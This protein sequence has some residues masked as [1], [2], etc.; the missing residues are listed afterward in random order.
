[1]S[2]I[3]NSVFESKQQIQV[4]QTE[5]GIQDNSAGTTLGEGYAQV[6]RK[7]GLTDAPLAGADQD[8]SRI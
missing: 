5:V 8:R 3:N 2:C 6:G 1:L 4:A 7:G